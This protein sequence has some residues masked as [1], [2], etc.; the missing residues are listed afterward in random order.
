MF[1][2]RLNAFVSAAFFVFSVS[3][4]QFAA[5]QTPSKEDL[6]EKLK[7]PAAEP[8]QAAQPGVIIMQSPAREMGPSLG[9]PAP[10]GRRRPSAFE[11]DMTIGSSASGGRRS[12]RKE[13]TMN[14]INVHPDNTVNSINVLPVPTP[15]APP[16]SVVIDPDKG[17]EGFSVSKGERDKLAEAVR[18]A[19]YASADLTVYFDFNS[20]TITP[21][22]ARTLVPLGE[23]LSD[24]RLAGSTF[25]I[26]GHTDAK[27]SSG[28]NQQLSEK[29]SKEIRNFLMTAFNLSG[30]KLIPIGYG[31]EQLK[32]PADPYAAENRRVQIINLTKN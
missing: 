28:Y 31:M 30:A 22:A 12:R 1:N 3:W 11:M 23:A 20:T 13:P 16:G 6:I 25:L 5:G 8:G 19:G 2:F 18:R 14:S 26:A 9:S 10:S 32:N 21:Q 24:P 17:G 15:A 29:R 27:G 4:P 7:N